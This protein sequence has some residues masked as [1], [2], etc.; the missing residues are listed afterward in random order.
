MSAKA[1]AAST[2]LEEMKQI[3]EEYKIWKKNSPF[4]CT[5]DSSTRSIWWRGLTADAAPLC[6]PC[7]P[8]A[9]IRF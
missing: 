2:A 1:A 4:L 8:C 3:D 6:G 9:C 5:N 7:S